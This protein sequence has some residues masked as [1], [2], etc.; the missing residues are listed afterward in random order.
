[1][2]PTRWRAEA[3]LAVLLAVIMVIAGFA[4]L[5]SVYTIPVH[6]DAAAVASRLPS[7]RT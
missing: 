2:K 3:A 4:A 1:M 5:R 7:Q 6:K